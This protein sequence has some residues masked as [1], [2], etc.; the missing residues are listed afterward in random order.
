MLYLKIPLYRV[1]TPSSSL[2]G[3]SD[4]ALRLP[5]TNLVVAGP[6]YFRIADHPRTDWRRLSVIERVNANYRIAPNFPL[7]D[8]GPYLELSRALG[9]L[10]RRMFLR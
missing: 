2:V 10:F 3:A 1:S 6:D 4:T 7:A 8:F 5:T 9:R